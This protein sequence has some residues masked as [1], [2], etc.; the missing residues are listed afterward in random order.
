MPHFTVVPVTE[1]QKDEYCSVEGINY[2]D[3]HDSRQDSQDLYDDTISSDGH[4][5]IRE[6]SPFLASSDP[7]KG[8]HLYDRNLALFEVR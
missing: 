2:V 6:S 7:H 5:S 1:K 3:Y 8:F 4:G